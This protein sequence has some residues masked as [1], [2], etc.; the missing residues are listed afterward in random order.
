[1][2]VRCCSRDDRALWV[3]MMIDFFISYP[4]LRDAKGRCSLLTFIS[5]I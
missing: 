5:S 4:C 2:L 1:M 3:Q